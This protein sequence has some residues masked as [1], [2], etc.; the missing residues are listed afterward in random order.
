MHAKFIAAIPADRGLWIVVLVFAAIPVLAAWPSSAQSPDS[1]GQER[2]LK[3]KEG[4]SAV[5]D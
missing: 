2:T 1:S 4:F 5:G 3:M